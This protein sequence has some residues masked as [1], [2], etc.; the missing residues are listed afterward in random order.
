MRGEVIKRPATLFE[1]L[2]GHNAIPLCINVFVKN[3][4]KDKKL[5]TFFNDKM[6]L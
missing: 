3:L 1:R 6:D 5:G 4:S 2:G